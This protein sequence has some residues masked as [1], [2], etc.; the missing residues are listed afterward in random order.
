MISEEYNVLTNGNA[1][2][3]GDHSRGPESRLANYGGRA[4]PAGPEKCG[5]AGP[6]KAPAASRRLRREQQAPRSLR[7]AWTGAWYGP[8]PTVSGGERGSVPSSR[9]EA[10]VYLRR[11]CTNDFANPYASSGGIA[12]EASTAL[13]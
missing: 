12:G 9:T 1:L 13:A 10:S 3:D 4:D 11:R 6:A 8:S 5:D 7:G 2:D